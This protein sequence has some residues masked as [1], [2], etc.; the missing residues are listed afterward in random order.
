[1]STT[2]FQNY[3]EIK[4]I[5]AAVVIDTLTIYIKSVPGQRIPR[6]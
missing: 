5:K 1:M 2:V 4:L 6:M 3:L